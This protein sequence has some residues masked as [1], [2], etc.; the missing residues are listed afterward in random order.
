MTLFKVSA[1]TAEHIGDRPEQQDRVAIVTSR[2][3]PG[4]LLA[5]V[6]DGMGGRTG[7]RMAAD[8]VVRTADSLFQ[9]TGEADSASAPLLQQIAAEAHT[10]VRLTAISSEKEPHST[11][12]AL[13]VKRNHA[14]WAH[15][16]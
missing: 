16:G 5:V 4:A 9:E 8:Q 11:M 10:V 15:S 2:R 6:A 7:G 12:V 14:V 1:C 3:N 13:I